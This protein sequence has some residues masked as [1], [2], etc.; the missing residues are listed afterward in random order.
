MKA[1]APA[2]NPLLKS[3]RILGVGF[4]I[5]SLAACSCSDNTGNTNNP[6]A[7][8]NPSE[9]ESPSG[10]VSPEKTVVADNAAGNSASAAR[11]AG[12]PGTQTEGFP[13]GKAR[14]N[15]AGKSGGKN[16]GK[17]DTQE[18]VP[19]SQVKSHTGKPGKPGT[20]AETVPRGKSRSMPLP[21][22]PTHGSGTQSA[23]KTGKSGRESVNTLGSIPSK[24]PD[25][26]VGIPGYALNNVPGK[27]PDTAPSGGKQIANETATPDII[28]GS[29]GN[30]GLAVPAL[31][32]EIGGIKTFRFAWADVSGETEYRLLEKTGGSSYMQVATLPA[33]TTSY[34]LKVFL[35]RRVNARYILQAC[36]GAGC[37][38]SMAVGVHGSL[39]EA[40]GYIKASN[41]GNEDRFGHSVAISGDG[42]TLAV[43]APAEDG[44]AAGINGD[45]N[46]NSASTSGAVYIFTRGKAGNWAQQAYMKAS[47]IRVGEEF[48][49]ALALSDDGNTLAVGAGRENSEASRIGGDVNA[50]EASGGVY[51]FTRNAGTWSQQ[52]FMKASNLAD[53][54]ASDSFGVSVALSGDGKTLAVGADGEGSNATGVNG[55]QNNELAKSSGAVYVFVRNGNDWIQHAYV[56][57]SNTESGDHFGRSVSLSN[58]GGTLAVGA[59]GEDSAA[60]GINGNQ[61]DNSA[62]SSGAVYVFSRNGANWTQHAYVKASNNRPGDLLTADEFGASVALAGNGKTLAVGAR[63]EDSTVTGVNGNQGAS[64]KHSSG[65]VYVFTRSGDNWAQQAYVKASN[66]GWGDEFGAAV[67]LSANGNTLAVGAPFEDSAATGINGDED[68]NMLKSPGAAY[69][70]TRSGGNW[71][72]RAYVKATN[73]MLVPRNPEHAFGFAV[74]LADGGD[75]LA[76]GAP[77]ED[78]AATGINGNQNDTFA[79]ASGAVYL[80]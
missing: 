34:D 21:D 68:N 50:A 49:Y 3:T 11:A 35:P 42:N 5:A 37:A 46:S 44:G 59:V 52:I 24:A 7:T 57:A 29:S 22:D 63:F 38:S 47:N 69:V 31:T 43:G 13:G 60:A 78:S 54:A 70:F 45:Q 80:Y 10:A 23:G 77:F 75:T 48:G 17:A 26:M 4:L 67:A 72:Q 79:G 16:A 36:T 6:P 71:I 19:G 33:D 73:T 61:N 64:S 2:I 1:A 76:V 56:K 30:S 55:D 53:K 41:T 66:T 65:A 62:I 14:N 39:A 32:L 8:E 28:P 15:F 20:Q 25:I 9:T 27:S 58:D 51:I 74:A 12:K 40:V 18:N